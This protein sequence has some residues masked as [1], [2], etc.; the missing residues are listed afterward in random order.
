[1]NK[2]LSFILLAACICLCA[3]AQNPVMIPSRKNAKQ[4][5]WKEYPAR[6]L[7]SLKGFKHLKADDRLDEYGGYMAK[8]YE[9]T[10]FFHTRQIDGR[11]WII[12]PLG[13]PYICKGMAV[14]TMGGSDRQKEA[15]AKRYANDKGLS[16]AECWA[17]QEMD[18]LRGYG[19]NGLGAWSTVD[20]VR[21]AEHPMPYTVIVSPMGRY[22]GDHIKRYGGKYHQ[23]GWQHYR[24]DLAMVF[25]PQ[26]DRY[27]E[28]EIS[29]IEKYK[30]DPYLL[31]Y[32]TDNEIPWML[33][34]LDRHLT[35][36][37]KD[38]AAYLA[39]KEWFDAR[40]GHKATA[41]EI[42]PEDREAFLYFYIETYLAKVHAAIRKI[43]P[44]H[45]YLGCRFTQ[46]KQE[47][48]SKAIFQ[49][50]GKYMDII[51]INHYHKWQPE[52]AQMAQWAEWS[53]KPFLITE[54][55]TK[56]EDSGLPNN[57]GAGWNVH[58]QRERGWF[59]QNF[60]MELLKS[61]SCVGWHWFKY[62]DNDPQN[63][64]TDESNRD[65]NKG[66]V[67]WDFEPYTEL[68]DEMKQLN[69]NVWSLIRYFDKQ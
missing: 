25:D 39:V 41:D 38:E 63:L 12:D 24:F 18:F 8:T 16:A 29:R 28:K 32:F 5:D 10:G 43:D 45:M 3:A 27:V 40:K 49:A 65:S 56:G 48:I 58:T 9:A 15:G 6:T 53:G 11:W 26:F 47:L 36:L 1:M 61:R 46:Q 31:G 14:F 66:V 55:Y 50:S 54:F 64:K 68:L 23:A 69:D 52:A 67:K 22:R 35:L 62:M 60:T 44:N 19:F 20:V 13:H 33:D 21:K 51:S 17:Q 30:D 37:A 2:R 59:Y 7:D 57:T 42:T 34:A 4:Q